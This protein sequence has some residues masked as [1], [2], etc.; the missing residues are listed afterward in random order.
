[1]KA[2]LLQ[3][4]ELSEAGRNRDRVAAQGAGLVHRAERSKT[5][6]DVG[7]ATEHCEWQAAADHFA[8]GG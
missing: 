2:R 8:E 7:T 3:V 6:H 4:F 5:L 1:M